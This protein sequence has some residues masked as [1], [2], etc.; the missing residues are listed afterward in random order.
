MSQRQPARRRVSAPSSLLRAVVFITG[1]LWTGL[2]TAQDYDGLIA[3]ALGARN[4]GDLVHAQTLLEQAREINPGSAEALYLLGL[5]AANQ[6][7]YDD[8]LQLLHQALALDPGNL[9]ILIARARVKS[10]SG[11][12]ADAVIE[13]ESIAR[14]HPDSV[15]ARSLLA[16][17]YYYQGE[18][19]AAEDGFRNALRLD[20]TNLEA[21][22][23][24][25]DVL[26]A[27][28]RAVEAREQ[29]QKAAQHY[30]QAA[31]PRKRL[32]RPQPVSRL[33]RLDASG[34]RSWFERRD[35]RKWNEGMV[36]LGRKISD[37][38][39][40]NGRV[41]VSQRF[42]RKD[43][44][45]RGGIEHRFGPAFSAYLRGEGT[46]SADF[47][48]RWSV[49]AGG[50]A[51]LFKGAGGDGIGPLWLTVDGRQR[52]YAIGH[53]QNANIG[54]HQYLLR[55][56]VELTARWIN[57]FN[58]PENRHLQGWMARLDVLPM[59]SLRVYGGYATS[60]DSDRGRIAVTDAVFGGLAVDI[61]AAFALRF[62]FAREDRRGA[63]IRNNLAAGLTY[64]F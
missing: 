41:Q 9:E 16:R 10:W 42:G 19:D 14:E 43:V 50:Q 25:G 22:L 47:L 55:G 11:Q 29:F 46:P 57:T 44:A 1:L 54:L 31:E 64:K 27:R 3:S 53:I 60:P 52:R 12:V 23:G 35:L 39:W 38:T 48:A 6:K 17:L 7:R 2:V 18:L 32:E 59:D 62:D 13:A 45:L 33:W 36:Q 26:W 37:A 4:A 5:V 30:P 58:N 15:E 61:S 49:E 20:P 51:R 21:L 24:L 56:R 34:S 40:I 8:A 28:G 63:Y